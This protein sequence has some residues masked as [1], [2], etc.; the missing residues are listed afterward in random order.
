MYLKHIRRELS[1]LLALLLVDSEQVCFGGQ[2][3]VLELVY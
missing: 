3:E 2:I 1:S